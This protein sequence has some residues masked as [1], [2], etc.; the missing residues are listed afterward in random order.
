MSHV[1]IDVHVSMSNRF[2]SDCNACVVDALSELNCNTKVN[3]LMP[4]VESRAT[5]VTGVVKMA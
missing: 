3:I 5:T 4:R 2:Y 1:G